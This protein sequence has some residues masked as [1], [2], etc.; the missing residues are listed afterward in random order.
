M[1]RP[2]VEPA[3]RPRGLVPDTAS[4]A[5]GV[6]HVACQLTP[7][8]AACSVR[9]FS[10]FAGGT[11]GDRPA[12]RLPRAAS[13]ASSPLNIATRQKGEAVSLLK[14][15]QEPD[16]TH[17]WV[18]TRPVWLVSLRSDQAS[19]RRLGCEGPEPNACRGAAQE[20]TQGDVEVGILD[21]ADGPGVPLRSN[22]L[23]TSL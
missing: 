11:Y 3:T 2:Y 6:K 17:R 1:D 19:Q 22:R 12:K 23:Q 9:S 8:Y 5:F 20:K 4:F 14:H 18:A 16:A 10:P 15:P 13:G 7:V 21:R